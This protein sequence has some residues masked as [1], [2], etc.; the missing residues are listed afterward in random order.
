MKPKDLLQYL[1]KGDRTM[2]HLTKKP[3]AG[4]IMTSL[5]GLFQRAYSASLGQLGSIV[6]MDPPNHAF[7]N[8]GNQIQARTG[9]QGVPFQQGGTLGW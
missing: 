6:T 1:E 2:F 9:V 4:T 7:W 5:N 8:V 3:Q